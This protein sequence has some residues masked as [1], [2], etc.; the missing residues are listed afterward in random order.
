M[1]AFTRPKL[2]VWA[3]FGLALGIAAI[4]IALYSGAPHKPILASRC[5]MRRMG[6]RVSLRPG[7]P[8]WR[9]SFRRV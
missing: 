8:C 2:L 3:G 6:G 5:G 1:R 9:S 7:P 4:G